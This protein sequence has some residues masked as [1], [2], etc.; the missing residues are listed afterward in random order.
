MITVGIKKLDPRA[1]MPTQAHPGDAWDLYALDQRVL[2]ADVPVVIETG[3]ALELPTNV[4][5]WVTPRS[6]LSLK[7]V[8]VWN[9]PGLIDPSYRGQVG[10]ILVWNGKYG[11]IRDANGV[12]YHYNQ[13]HII[14]PGERIAQLSFELIPEVELIEVNELSE[15]ARGVGGFGSTGA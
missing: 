12:L 4:R 13:R 9:A 2:S 10:V 3:I 1:K 6:G 11:N 8:T 5:A 7:G 14:Q 15:T